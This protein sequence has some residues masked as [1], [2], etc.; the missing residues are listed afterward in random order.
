M[1]GIRVNEWLHNSGTGGIWQTSAGNVGIASSVPT[2]KLVVTGDANISGVTTANQFSGAAFIP[3]AGQLSHR[4]IIINGAMQVAQRAASATAQ[5][6]GFHT[7]DRIEIGSSNLENAADQAQVAVASGNDAY[8]A[9]F[10]KSFK[11]T[12][13]ANSA[14]VDD[15]LKVSYWIEAQDL[16]C[17]GWD[18]SS[19]SSNITLSFWVKSSVAQTFPC[20]LYHSD[21]TKGYSF[22]YSATTSWTRITHTIPGAAGQAIN[23]DNGQGILIQ[24]VQYMGTNYTTSDHTL[25]TWHSY[26][27]ADRCRDVTTTWINTDDATFEITGVQLEVGSVATPFEHR[28]FQDELRDC[29]RYYQQW[30]ASGQDGNFCVGASHLTSGGDQTRNASMLPTMLRAAPTITEFGNG[31]KVFGSGS[32]VAVTNIQ[33]INV[34]NG[35]N[36]LCWTCEHSDIGDNNEIVVVCNTDNGGAYLDA[37]L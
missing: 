32:E 22:N 15:Q 10:R 11:L 23:N 4:N 29:M 1:S 5:A 35:S 24:W 16:A 2:A 37:E 3:S 12:N 17:S 26:D 13:G 14:D 6:N 34:T 21:S 30:G 36:M 8:S 20:V 27:S 31:L 33:D 18:D 9:G 28:K 7:V 19:S 25:E